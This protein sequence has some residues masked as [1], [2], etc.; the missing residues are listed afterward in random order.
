MHYKCVIFETSF[1][2]TCRCRGRK[3]AGKLWAEGR[4]WYCNFPGH[5][6][7]WVYF[8]CAVWIHSVLVQCTH[9]YHM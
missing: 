9:D 8:M 4:G 6:R 2:L 1:L 5:Y 3:R 7:M